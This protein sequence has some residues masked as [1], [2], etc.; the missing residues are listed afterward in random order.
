MSFKFHWDCLGSCPVE[1]VLWVNK[2]IALMTLLDRYKSV[3]D[4]PQSHC[5]NDSEITVINCLC[6]VL[7][8]WLLSPHAILRRVKTQNIKIGK[9]KCYLY[10]LDLSYRWYQ[11][12]RAGIGSQRQELESK[13]HKENRYFCFVGT[14]PKPRFS[15]YLPCR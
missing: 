4:L 2:A 1:P 3:K 10:H 14:S 6:T 9:V 12:I 13:S 7:V 5:W 15:F 8:V 11:V